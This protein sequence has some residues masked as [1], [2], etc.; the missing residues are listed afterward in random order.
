VKKPPFIL[1]K[2]QEQIPNKPMLSCDDLLKLGVGE[3]HSSLCRWRQNG[4]GPSFI[5]IAGRY[6]YPTDSLAEWLEARFVESSSSKSKTGTS[7]K[8]QK[9]VGEQVEVQGQDESGSR[10]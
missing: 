4:D 5:K 2:I 7:D 10:V 9:Q 1:K 8:G 6:R 3:S